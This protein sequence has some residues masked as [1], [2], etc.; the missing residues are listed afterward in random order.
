MI[1]SAPQR[2]DTATGHGPALCQQLRQSDEPAP[3]H[4]KLMLVTLL[5]QCT[6]T[7]SNS[8]NTGR[9]QACCCQ[10]Q[11]S[12]RAR[13]QAGFPMQNLHSLPTTRSLRNPQ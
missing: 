3:I 8:L 5:H 13:K 11:E 7:A 10:A 2:G 9:R 12:T 1:G 4:R 6:G